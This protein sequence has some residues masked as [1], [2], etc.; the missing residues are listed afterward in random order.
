LIYSYGRDKQAKTASESG[1]LMSEPR[2][3]VFE[4]I[5]P[6]KRFYREADV[7]VV[8]DGR[9]AVR[10]DQ[11][12][13]RSPQGRPLILP[14]SA[15]AR[16]VA[17]EW[18]VQGARI[19]MAAMPATRLAHATLDGIAGV[20]ADTIASVASFA[21]SDL[22]CYFADMPASLRARQE[23]VWLPR[24]DW[25]RD[26]LGLD[27]ERALGIIHHDQP[28]A[29]LA[30]LEALACA[31]D[32]F[33]LAGLALGAQLF[34]SAILAMALARGRLGGAEAFDASQIDEAFQAEQWGEDAEAAART[35]SLRTEAIMLEA[36]FAALA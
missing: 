1:G 6:P 27:F 14:T 2:L 31:L 12:V 24:L 18:A 8:E 35:R 3:P 34:G 22:I 15:L 20:R 4:S 10:L 21:A 19:V 36:W 9:Y 7:A 11:R 33:R 25:A 30:A 28:A 23:A 29:A 13:A 16:L 26:E 5:Q 17:S 32:D